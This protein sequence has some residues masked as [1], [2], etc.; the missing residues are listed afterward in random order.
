M[1][2]TQISNLEIK[3]DYLQ[4]E[5]KDTKILL[6]WFIALG[7]VIM[8]GISQIAISNIGF[9]KVLLEKN[10]SMKYLVDQNSMVIGDMARQAI[11]KGWYKPNY[12]FREYVPNK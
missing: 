8:I 7:V 11:E 9:K 4:T 1:T 2:K 10:A 6:K 12:T 5:V 3:V